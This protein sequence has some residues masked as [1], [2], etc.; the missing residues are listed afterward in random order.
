MNTIKICVKMR[1][2]GVGYTEGG[3][4]NCTY[5]REILRI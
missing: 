1:G 2:K 4:A 5:V 3:V